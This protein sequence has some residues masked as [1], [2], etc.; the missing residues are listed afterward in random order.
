M[1][2][3]PFIFFIAD[4]AHRDP[5]PAGRV[6]TILNPPQIV[7]P[8]VAGKTQAIEFDPLTL[9]THLGRALDADDVF[10]PESVQ[11]LEEIVIGKTTIGRQP[12]PKRLDVVKDQLEGVFDHRQ[13]VTFHPAFERRLLVGSPED[14]DRSQSDL[15]RDDQQMRVIFSGPIDREP[16]FPGIRT[17]RSA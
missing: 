12:N 9:I 6:A 5:H 2:D 11:Q 17:W 1:P 7:P 4:S 3:A 16:N 14:R 15:E 10:D 13:F 8:R